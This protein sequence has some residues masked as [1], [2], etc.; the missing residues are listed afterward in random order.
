MEGQKREDWEDGSTTLNMKSV[1]EKDESKG[2]T[3]HT[4]LKTMAI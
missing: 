1:D 3:I 2:V 4:L